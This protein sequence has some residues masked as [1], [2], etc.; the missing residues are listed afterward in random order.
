MGIYEQISDSPKI[1]ISPNL[2]L[3]PQ[4]M[5]HSDLVNQPQLTEPKRNILENKNM[6][7]GA[8]GHF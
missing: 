5:L 6:H 8:N 2:F 1:Q 7:L 3:L 4:P